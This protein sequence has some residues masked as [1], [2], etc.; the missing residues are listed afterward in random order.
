MQV[1]PQK[2]SQPRNINYTQEWH[3]PGYNYVGPGTDIEARVMNGIQPINTLDASALIHDVEMDLIDQESADNNMVKNIKKSGNMIDKMKGNAVDSIFRM[4]RMTGFYKP[5]Q[6]PARGVS[7]RDRAKAILKNDYPEIVFSE[8]SVSKGKPK[9]LR[10]EANVRKP[11]DLGYPDPL[12]TIEKMS[13]PPLIGRQPRQ[14]KPSNHK[15]LGGD[16][17][18]TRTDSISHVVN[19]PYHDHKR[20]GIVNQKLRNYHNPIVETPE[21]KSDF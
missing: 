1:F 3:L 18:L 19:G 10:E 9:N 2:N 7:L 15:F 21:P 14:F 4:N 8:R 11:M 17:E 12:K 20:D 6:D 16:L 13:D 5:K